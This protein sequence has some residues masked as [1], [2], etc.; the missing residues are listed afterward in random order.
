[1][2][3]CPYHCGVVSVYNRDKE[4]LVKCRLNGSWAGVAANDDGELSAI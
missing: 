2:A 4:G 1:M 3:A